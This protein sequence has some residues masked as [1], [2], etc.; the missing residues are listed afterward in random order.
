MEIPKFKLELGE[1]SNALKTVLINVPEKYKYIFTKKMDESK[2]R[3]LN[4]TVL[5][6]QRSIA[7]SELDRYIKNTGENIQECL[8]NIINNQINETSYYFSDC[9]TNYEILSAEDIRSKMYTAKKNINSLTKDNLGEINKL[10]QKGLEDTFIQI[11]L[12]AKLGLSPQDIENLKNYYLEDMKKGIEDT[13]DEILKLRDDITRLYQTTE[14]ELAKNK[15]AT[16]EKENSDLEQVSSTNSSLMAEITPEA[17]LSQKSVT[18]AEIGLSF[19]DISVVERYI[20][21]FA[22]DM[23]LRVEEGY[24]VAT[25]ASGTPYSIQKKDDVISFKSLSDDKRYGLKVNSEDQSISV[26]TYNEEN[27]VNF[28]TSTNTVTLAY[29]N[30]GGRKEYEFHFENGNV[31]AFELN[32]EEKKPIENVDELIQQIESNGVKINQVLQISK[33]LSVE[34][35]TRS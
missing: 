1:K 33:D 29:A 8:G 12:D 16:P 22:P 31:V 11:N 15:L 13:K 32:G 23:Q 2:D 21:V 14:D 34:G 25:D 6:K 9:V 5:D 27:L 3:L 7:A 35:P 4:R 20:N 30:D 19:L 10:I 28:E 18:E 26:K 24:V 17:E